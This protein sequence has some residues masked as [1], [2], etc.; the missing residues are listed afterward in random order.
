MLRQVLDL[1]LL[2]LLVR[3]ASQDAIRITVVLNRS[4]PRLHA[5]ACAHVG[6]RSRA[7]AKELHSLSCR[8]DRVVLIRL[9][10]RVHHV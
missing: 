9:R 1:V 4:R 7:R 10:H 2:V 8:S 3:A 5:L 6:L